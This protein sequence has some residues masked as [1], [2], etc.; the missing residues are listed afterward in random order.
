VQMIQFE[1]D[2]DVITEPG[3][4][5]I[6]AFGAALADERLNGIAL[7]VVGHTDSKGSEAYNDSLSERR[8]KAVFRYLR[9]E[10]GLSESRLEVAWSGEAEPI[11]SNDSAEG[12]AQNRRVEMVFLQR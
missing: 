12:R 6:D 5:Q 4:V 3:K 11:A 8:A 2:S 9:E 1:F 10:V 7:K